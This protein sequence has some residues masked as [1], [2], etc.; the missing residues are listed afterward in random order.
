[1]TELYAEV[2]GQDAAVRALKAAARRPVH[3]YLL[4]GPPGTGKRAAAASFT[5]SLLCPQGGDGTCDVCRRVLAGIHPDMVVVEREGP[6]ITV[7]TARE[8]GRMAA[9]SPVEGDR[10]VLVLNDF[11][12]VREAGPAL[13]KTIEEPPKSTI[14][15]VL[16]EFIPAELVTIASRCVRIDFSPLSPAVISEALR[17]DGVERG[18]AD[19]LAEVADGRLDRARLL[20]GD[21]EFV[22]RR[23]T[24]MDIPSRLDGSGATAAR[25]AAEVVDL[26]D[27][28]VAPLRTMQDQ[29]TVEL[30]ARNARMNEINGKTAGGARAAKAGFKDLEER[31][32]RE[33]RRQRTDELKAGLAALAGVYRD[34]LAAGG[35][36]GA[37]AIEAVRLIQELAVNLAYNPNEVL[38]LQALLFA[39]S[40]IPATLAVSGRVG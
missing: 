3:A 38:Q 16:A 21:P 18:L 29:Q 5:A 15:V 37:E 23:Q 34:R 17:H 31:H 26:L 8:I 20:A 19:Q 32:K 40:R 13:L 2:L 9:R 25:L 14:F 27:R 35:P 4:A 36:G 39:L 33:L 11:H 22:V 12:L 10:K 1:V 6:F 7:D 30:E 28:S 24:W